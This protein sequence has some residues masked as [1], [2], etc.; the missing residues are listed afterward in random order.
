MRRNQ[1]NR[2]VFMLREIFP[3]KFENEYGG[4][5]TLGQVD[6]WDELFFP[7]S[8]YPTLRQLEMIVQSRAK[9]DDLPYELFF[10]AEDLDESPKPLFTARWESLGNRWHVSMDEEMLRML[11]GYLS[12]HELEVMFTEFERKEYGV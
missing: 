5:T 1:F 6:R 10:S 8:E 11:A 2:P 12:P 4:E 9:A 3:L 7:P